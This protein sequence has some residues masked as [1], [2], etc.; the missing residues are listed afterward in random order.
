[1]KKKNKQPASVNRNFKDSM[2][3]KLFS[4][5][6]TLLDLYNALSGSSYDSSAKIEINTLDDVLYMDMQNDISFTIEDKVIILIEHQS[7]INENLPLRFLLYIARVYEKIIDKQMV[8]RQKLMKI[9]SPELIVLYNGKDKFPDKKDLQLSDAFHNMPE[10]AEKYGSLELT[11]CVLNINAGHN[12][13]IVGKCTA[14]KGYVVFINEVREGINNGLELSAAIAEAVKYC[15]NNQI[16]QPF[17]TDHASEVQ[18]MLTTKFS[19]E[20]AKIVWREEGREEGIEQG[21]EQGTKIMAKKAKDTGI[22]STEQIAQISG[23]SVSE[24]EEL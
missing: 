1:M 10:Y 4:E 15:E 11:V 2:F 24:V 13:D 3:T 23:L 9:P 16:L 12:D 7:S 5:K 19:L 17:L 22:L 6:A 21:I 14:L 18:N 8:H 20:E